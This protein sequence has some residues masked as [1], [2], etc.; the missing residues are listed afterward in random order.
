[1]QITPASPIAPR[2][3]SLWRQQVDVVHLL[4]AGGAVGLGGGSVGWVGFNVGWSVGEEGWLGVGEEERE[5]VCSEKN[6][7]QK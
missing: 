2:R 5:D 3:R 4:F 7:D 1:M 6:R